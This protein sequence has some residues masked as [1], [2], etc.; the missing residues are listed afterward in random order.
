MQPYI[1]GIFVGWGVHQT[2]SM[3][4]T[5][6]SH[7]YI[8]K[9]I[10]QRCSWKPQQQQLYLLYFIMYHA[11][12]NT[13]RTWISQLFLFFKNNYTRINHCTFIHHKSHLKPF[14][15]YLP[16]IARKE[17]FSIIVWQMANKL[18]Y[19]CPYFSFLNAP[20]EFKV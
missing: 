19:E 2:S 6:L 4:H 8:G 1:G 18:A 15:S 12:T 14:L 5:S 7:V 17:Y 3:F 16:C 11:H 9:V 10:L 20:A 13:V